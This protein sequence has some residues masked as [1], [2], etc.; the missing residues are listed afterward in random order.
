MTHGS[1]KHVEIKHA[2]ERLLAT[3]PDW[4]KFYREVMGLHGLIRRAF[5][6]YEAMAEFEQTETSREIH[7]MLAELRRLP[8]PKET[9]EDTRVITVRIPKSLHEALRLEAYEH[10]TTMNKLCISKLVQ[11]ID[12]D[13]VPTVLEKREP[14]EIPEK[15]AEA[16]L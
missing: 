4:I 3:K 13:N 5:P 6:T 14:A 1:Q 11:F 16:G 2:V 9:A 10:H 8:P 12:T 15:E 7:R